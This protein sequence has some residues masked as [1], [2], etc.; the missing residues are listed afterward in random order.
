MTGSRRRRS[1]HTRVF[2]SEGSILKETG[3]PIGSPYHLA[4]QDQTF[5]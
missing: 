1:T 5:L 3:R 2:N 4:A